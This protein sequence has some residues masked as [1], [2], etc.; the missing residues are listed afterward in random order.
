MTD[1]AFLF[2]VAAMLLW[3]VA[4]VF[5]KLALGT[6][7]PVAALA[8][9]SAFVA[10]VML[11]FVG[12][13]GGWAAV[14]GASARDVALIAL[15]GLFAGLLGGLAYFYALKYGETGRVVPTV[16]AY[17]LVTLLLGLALMGEKLTVGKGLG[18]ILIAAGVALV[19][20]R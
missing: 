11:A 9:R 1:N 6:V 15:E 17:P 16:A 8:I 13:T 7:E 12:L 2:A 5:G 4:P 19:N 3:G 14:A 10:A 20:Y 18:A